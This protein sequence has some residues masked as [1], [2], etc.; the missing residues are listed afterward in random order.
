MQKW[1]YILTGLAGFLAGLAFVLFGVGVEMFGGIGGAP[2]GGGTSSSGI[3]HYMMIGLI[4]G[5]IG[6]TL[7]F[8]GLRKSKDQ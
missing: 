2:G 8:R 3:N 1:G 5:A 7:F 6:A 4:I